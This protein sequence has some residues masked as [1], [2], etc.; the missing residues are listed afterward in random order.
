MQRYHWIKNI[1][2][3]LKQQAPEAQGDYFAK[4]VVGRDCD[5]LIYFDDSMKVKKTVSINYE[6]SSD[7]P[8]GFKI[9]IIYQIDWHKGQMRKIE[10]GV[11]G[12]WSLYFVNGQAT[13]ENITKNSFTLRTHDPMG[14]GTH[15]YVKPEGCTYYTLAS[16]EPYLEPPRLTIRQADPHVVE[17]FESYAERNGLSN[18]ISQ[19]TRNYM[20]YGEAIV[21]DSGS[22][23]T[24][25]FIAV[26]PASVSVN[27]NFNLTTPL[28]YTVVN[29]SVP[30][31]EPTEDP[32]SSD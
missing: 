8:R 4:I 5:L 26:D 12:D 14:H 16:G 18:T 31:D 32:D 13:V 1:T 29:F 30:I 17:F 28:E 19:M 6:N 7:T 22:Q 27:A 21:F 24:F 11:V 2:Q 23:D 20:T 3:E 25:P 9:S 15:V 10:N